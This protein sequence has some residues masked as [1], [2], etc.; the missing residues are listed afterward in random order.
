VTVLTP[1]Q[2]LQG[3]QQSVFAPL[4]HGDQSFSLQSS[5]LSPTA[6]PIGTSTVSGTF[7]GQIF[8]VSHFTF[9]AGS[10]DQAFQTLLLSLTTDLNALGANQSAS[11]AH[12]YTLTPLT[13]VPIPPSLLLFG[14]GVVVLMLRWMRKV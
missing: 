7:S 6:T 1:P 8:P 14:S 11:I 4:S 5:F 3:F 13:P 12:N 9:L 10:N 2:T